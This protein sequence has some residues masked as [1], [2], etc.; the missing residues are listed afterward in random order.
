MT[1]LCILSKTKLAGLEKQHTEALNREA[2]EAE[3]IATTELKQKE[4]A[5]LKEQEKETKAR[6]KNSRKNSGS[7]RHDI[8][9]T[10]SLFN[11]R[12]LMRHRHRRVR[13]QRANDS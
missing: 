7:R 13:P 12:R 1:N 6:Q 8:G 4:L 2:A 3:A 5:A 10:Q 9:Q 11:V